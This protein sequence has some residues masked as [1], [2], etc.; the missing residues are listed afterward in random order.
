MSLWAADSACTSRSANWSRFERCRPRRRWWSDTN[1]TPS[2]FLPSAYATSK[3]NQSELK[4]L[5]NCFARRL[6]KLFR[7][8]CKYFKLVLKIVIFISLYENWFIFYDNLLID[9]HCALNVYLWVL[10]FGIQVSSCPLHIGIQYIYKFL[11]ILNFY[12]ILRS[13]KRVQHCELNLALTVD[14]LEWDRFFLLVHFVP[15]R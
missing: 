6:V 9:I 5:S 3:L 8:V 2:L 1:D 10:I 4:I 14:G 13:S 15:V 12:R 7:F 11:H